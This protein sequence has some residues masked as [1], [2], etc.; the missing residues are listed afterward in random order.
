LDELPSLEERLLLLESELVLALRWD[1]PSLL[2]AVHRSEITRGRIEE[3][4]LARLSGLKLS[5]ARI[6]L[7]KASFDLPLILRQDPLRAEKLYLVRGLRWGG[8]RGYSNAY[9]ALN[10]HREFL[11]EDRVRVL[12]WLTERESRQLARHAP[13]FWAFRHLVVAFSELPGTQQEHE[14]LAALQSAPAQGRHDP[15]AH[16]SLGRVLSQLGCY[17][18]AIEQFFQARRAGSGVADSLLP[19]ARAYLGMQRPEQAERLMRQAARQ[20]PIPP[21]D[22]RA[23]ADAYRALGQEQKATR[24]VKSA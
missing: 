11:V 20:T 19:A 13:D 18:P 21:E 3:Q 16:L 14:Q 9:R 7:D 17:E 1:R 2:A 4:L 8:G 10:M 6:R 23:L 15:Q 24:L 12:F 5:P 22:W